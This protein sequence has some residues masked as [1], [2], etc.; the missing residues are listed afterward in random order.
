MNNSQFLALFALLMSLLL[1][2]F[3]WWVPVDDPPAIDIG[4][5]VERYSSLQTP[6]QHDIMLRGVIEKAE[7][8][9]DGKVRITLYDDADATH[10][11]TL[12]GR[13]S[14]FYVDEYNR[15]IVSRLTNRSWG[16]VEEVFMGED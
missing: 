6:M 1:I 4:D 8:V 12:H 10:E 15:I 9:G 16:A 5:E 2:A 13:A 14:D 11:I 7:D 3:T